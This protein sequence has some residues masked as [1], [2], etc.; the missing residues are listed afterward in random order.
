MKLWKN[1]H[2]PLAR[3]TGL[4]KPVST[5][6]VQTGERGKLLSQDFGRTNPGRKKVGDEVVK[7]NGSGWM[8]N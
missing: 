7:Y 4:K 6:L 2:K 8:E 3:V 1:V 5:G